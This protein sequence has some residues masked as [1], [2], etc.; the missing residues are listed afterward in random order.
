MERQRFTKR[1]LFPATLVFAV[2]AVS[3]AGYYVSRRLE[4]DFLR[5]LLA[6]VFG[7]TWF[8]SV[9]F[10]AMYVYI[11][12][13]LR[14]AS[15]KESILAS[16][17]TPFIWMTK[18]CAKLYTSYDLLQCL[19]Y[20]LN[21]LNFWLVFLMGLE[22]GIAS[23]ISR[24]ILKG[25]GEPVTVVTAGSLATAGVSLFLVI[26]GYAWGKGENLYVIFLAGFRF[27]FGS[28]V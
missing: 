11:V 4:A 13:S 21:P 7:T 12:S 17:V 18:E 19:Y 9:A 25:R 3:W 27:F 23:M 22:L 20:Y 16:A 5:Q 2:M 15:K 6:G 28:G 14:G 8:I 24:K 10:G 1:T 26:A